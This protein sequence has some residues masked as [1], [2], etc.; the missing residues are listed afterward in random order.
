MQ[1]KSSP[2]TVVSETG[3]ENYNTRLLYH[4]SKE[5]SSQEK[6]S[7]NWNFILYPESAPANW[8]DIIDETRIE[9]VE[10]PIHD[11][12]INPDGEIKKTH[13]HITLLYPS[14]KSFEQVEELTKSL[15]ATIPMKCLSVKGSIRYMVHKD[16]P[17]K[18]QYSW[19]EIKCHGGVSISDLIKPTATERLQIQEDILEFIRDNDIFE[20]SD[21][22]DCCTLMQKKDWTDICLNYSTISINAYI[23][24][25]KYKKIEAEAERCN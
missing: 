17:D 1:N 2:A 15:N 12:D 9:W 11:K 23:R 22:L 7:S 25:R 4:M 13:Y 18:Y 16:H 21:L 19:D 5:K 3:E 14:L 8:R 24:S 20:F 6:R 10:S